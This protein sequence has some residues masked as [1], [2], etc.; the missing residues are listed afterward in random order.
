MLGPV[1]QDTA[2]N[3]FC[4]MRGALAIGLIVVLA[5]ITT[6]AGQVYLVSESFQ[7]GETGN[8]RSSSADMAA[9]GGF[10]T[11]ESRA[12]N[13]GPS[14]PNGTWDI[15][16]YQVASGEVELV[17]VGEGGQSGWGPSRAASISDDGRYV[18]F[19]SFAPNF[20][21]D[22]DNDVP[23]VFVR[24][25]QTQTTERISVHSLGT[26]ASDWSWGPA[27]SGDGAVVA[28]VSWADNLVDDDTNAVGDVFL[29]DLV[30]GQTER[31]S[32]SSAG[33]QGNDYS[34]GKG[35]SVSQDGRYLAFCSLADNLVTDDF[36][37][38]WDVFVRDRVAG[39]TQRISVD[40][41]GVEG[42]DH[43]WYPSISADGRYV[44][45]WS[46]ADDLVAGDDN[47]ADDCFVHDRQTGDTERVSL[48][49][50]GTQANGPSRYPRISADGALVIFQSA[51][52]NLDSDDLN[53]Y[54]DVFLR[55]RVA[56]TTELVSLNSDDEQANNHCARGDVS[57]DGR[58]VSFETRATNFAVD[59]NQAEDVFVRLIAEA[60]PCPGDFNGD[61]FRNVT[62]FTLFA[63][64]FGSVLGD[65]N[66]DPD[67]D[68][69]G[70][71]T[72]N[73]TD[74]TIF[75]SYF[76]EPCL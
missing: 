71:G 62:D 72:I 67:M 32:L 44:A 35:I 25:R 39:T 46:S 68:M 45:F 65:P 50:A 40:S 8:F 33:L 54:D 75:V 41:A 26:Q 15:Y 19:V 1:Q 29:H 64:A 7:P 57:A 66:Y 51:A 4:R 55:D 63:A 70:N 22:D 21:P 30:T 17:S 12:S 37:N 53:G 36:N 16:V 3:P 13:L 61:L 43:S 31:I 2:A 38:S 59:Y 6:P 24:D 48:D 69:N 47:N 18:A 42:N 27:I 28:F 58:L 23:D 52:T 5:A 14:D 11:F 60:L 9:G 20:A 10:V 56:Q 49:S 74:F 34:G 76:G 73:V